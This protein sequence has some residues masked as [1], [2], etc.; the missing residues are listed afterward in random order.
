MHLHRV[1]PRARSRLR[2]ETASATRGGAD[3]AVGVAYAPSPAELD[4]AALTMRAAY[5]TNRL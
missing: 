4:A 3:E 5:H 1:W 2:A